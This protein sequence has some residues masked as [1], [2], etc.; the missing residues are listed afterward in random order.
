MLWLVVTVVASSVSS[1]SFKRGGILTVLV[2]QSANDLE[3]ERIMHAHQASNS[4][5]SNDDDARDDFGGDPGGSQEPLAPTD[6]ANQLKVMKLVSVQTNT[7]KRQTRSNGV[8]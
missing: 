6:K 4:G 8:C 2:L 1:A 7:I 3:L 5:W